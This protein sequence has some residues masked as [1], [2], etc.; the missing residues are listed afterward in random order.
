VKESW[1]PRRPWERIVAIERAR[2]TTASIALN[3]V[4]RREGV[5]TRVSGGLVARGPG[6]R[7]WLLSDQI[8]SQ[9]EHAQLARLL[10]GLP[11][12]VV[13]RAPRPHPG[14]PPTHLYRRSG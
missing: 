4:D 3:A 2:P 7:R 1:P 9:D 10:A 6:R 11:R 12:P 13:M 8:E 5:S 14:A